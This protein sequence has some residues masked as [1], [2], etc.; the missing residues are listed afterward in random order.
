MKTDIHIAALL[1]LAATA[2]VLILLFLASESQ[3][4][5]ALFRSQE[6][7]ESVVDGQGNLRVPSDYRASYEF[8]GAWAIGVDKGMGSREL[9]TVY[10]SPG[11]VAAYHTSRHFPD[12]TVL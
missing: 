3:S 5:R 11:A 8:L 1:L 10:A 6:T 2:V 4:E 12:G 7:L 9:H